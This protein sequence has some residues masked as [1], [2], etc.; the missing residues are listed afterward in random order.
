LNC[1]LGALT[2]VLIFDIARRTF[3]PRV[4]VV[5]GIAAASMPTLVLWSVL[6]LKETAVLLLAVSGLWA[7]LMIEEKSSLARSASH[8][9]V[10]IASVLASFDLRL[11]TALVLI[12]LAGIPVVR[13]AR[14]LVPTWAIALAGL[15]CVM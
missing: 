7:I 14:K 1:G 9:V 4:A 10:L 5:A 6:T 13:H 8:F 11:T 3:S 2:A 12:P 15:L